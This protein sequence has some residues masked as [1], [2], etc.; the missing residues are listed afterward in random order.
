MQALR[1]C[2]IAA[3]SV[4]SLTM[5]LLPVIAVTCSEYHKNVLF[6]TSIHFLTVCILRF[7]VIK[8]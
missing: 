7:G 4:S 8:V 1:F 6:I 2:G 5:F 3:L